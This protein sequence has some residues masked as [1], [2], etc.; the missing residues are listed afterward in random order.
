MCYNFC[1][2]RPPSTAVKGKKGRFTSHSE[3]ENTWKI[4]SQMS[5]RYFPFIMYTF[6]SRQPL[7]AERIERAGEKSRTGDWKKNK[8]RD[9]SSLG[10]C[11]VIYCRQ[12]GT[13]E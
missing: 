10:K 4:I 11:E 8:K 2:P 12:R 6:L 9:L 7:R 1:R 13:K 5:P 3:M